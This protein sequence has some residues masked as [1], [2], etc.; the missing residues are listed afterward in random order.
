MIGDDVQEGIIGLH[1]GFNLKFQEMMKEFDGLL[2]DTR[3]ISGV[4]VR[5]ISKVGDIEIIA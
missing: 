4:A 5:E 2:G 1:D 3:V